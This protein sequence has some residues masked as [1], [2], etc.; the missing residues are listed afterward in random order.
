MC[1]I[2]PATEIHTRVASVNRYSTLGTAEIVR[3]A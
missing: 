2:M 1:R 3:D